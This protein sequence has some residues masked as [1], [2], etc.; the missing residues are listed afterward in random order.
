VSKG[1]PTPRWAGAVL[2]AL[3]IA[4]AGC[5]GDDQPEG[6]VAPNVVQPGA[7]GEPSQT[8]SEDEL[9]D[10]EPPQHTDADVAFMQGMIH[11]HAQALRMSTLAPRNGAGKDVRLL[12]KRIKLSQ[13]AEIEQMQ[14]WLEE[15]GEEVPVLHPAHGHAHGI[16]TGRRMPGMLTAPQLKRLTQARGRAFERLFLR[17]WSSITRARS[18][19]SEGCTTRAVASSRPPTPSRDTSRPIR[20]SRSAA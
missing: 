1:R 15:R 16:G 9:D 14:T 5:A 3:A 18:S 6:E 2:A 20:R 8:L 19:W 10:L 13:E 11:H 17:A 4:L 12:A 7:P